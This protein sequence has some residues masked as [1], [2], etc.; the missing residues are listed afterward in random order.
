VPL[1]DETSD[2]D[3]DDEEENAD[4]SEL[5]GTVHRSVWC[6]CIMEMATTAMR[7]AVD[8]RNV[9]NQESACYVHKGL[10]RVGDHT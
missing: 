8:P 6:L 4:A 1:L 3:R 7:N 9:M 2:E 5:M 10:Y